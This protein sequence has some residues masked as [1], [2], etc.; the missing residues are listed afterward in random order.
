MPTTRLAALALSLLPALAAAQPT[1]PAATR[2][3]FVATVHL[4]GNTNALRAGA[5]HPVEP[6]PTAA[7]PAGGGLI[8][9]P[10]APD[11]AWSV[12]A[13]V[14]Q[15]AQ[16][17]VRQGDR[18]ALTFVAVHGASHRILIDGQT[19]PLAL[20]RG[21]AGTISFLAE[22]PGSIGFRGDGRAPS[23]AGEVLVLPR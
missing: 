17:V 7:L 18:V 23:M 4:D 16:I 6:F 1:E 5:T 11:G 10:P 13:F 22:R 21:E 14:F 3:F 20:R 15:P 12:R 2:Q 8:L 9:T 19:E